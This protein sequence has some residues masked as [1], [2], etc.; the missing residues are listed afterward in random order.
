MDAL[1]K[2]LIHEVGQGALNRYFDLPDYVELQLLLLIQP[3]QGRNYDL[4][5]S[6]PPP[7]RLP[8]EAE[9][10]DVIDTANAEFAQEGTSFVFSSRRLNYERLQRFSPDYVELQLLLLIQPEQGR[11]YD[12]DLS[13][14]PPTRLPREAEWKPTLQPADWEA[15]VHKQ[16]RT[17]A[18]VAYLETDLRQPTVLLDVPG[19]FTTAIYNNDKYRWNKRSCNYKPIELYVH[20]SHAWPKWLRFPGL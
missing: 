11:N 12:L 3:E 17:V 6:V 10:R 16:G 8:R 7:T 2:E 19:R 5:L 9:W 20:N 14:P 1:I 13:V 18:D 4:D 15:S